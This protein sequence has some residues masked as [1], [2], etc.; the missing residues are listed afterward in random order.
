MR[1]LSFHPQH[2][3]D[4]EQSG[5]TLETIRAAK[6]YTVPPDEIDKKL[7]GLAKGVVS[8]LAFPY[9]G[10]DGFERFKVWREEGKT[11]PKYIQKIGTAN[12]LYFP[13]GVDL[14]GDSHLLLVEGEKKALA[15][16][17]AGFQVVGIG[18]VQLA[19]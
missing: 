3:A 17:Q 19:N 5:L 6:V 2:S 7:D 15:L 16:L 11:G 10:C 13:P 18:G 8:A 4:L 14:A 1:F 12:H 9:H